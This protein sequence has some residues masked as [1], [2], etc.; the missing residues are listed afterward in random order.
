MRCSAKFAAN[1]R[2]FGLHIVAFFAVGGTELGPSGEEPLPS[3]VVVWSWGEERE[4]AQFG[5]CQVLSTSVASCFWSHPRRV[6]LVFGVGQFVAAL[7]RVTLCIEPSLT[8]LDSK[9]FVN[10]SAT[11]GVGQFATL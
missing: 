5:F 6:S 7:G 11:V 2:H 9:L 4:F 1:R 8:W 10:V 3:C